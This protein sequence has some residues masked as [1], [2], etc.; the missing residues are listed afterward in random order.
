VLWPLWD[1]KR[2]AVHDKLARTN[3]VRRGA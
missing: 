3:V 1:R 2:Q